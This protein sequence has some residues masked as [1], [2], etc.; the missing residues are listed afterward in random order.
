MSGD[1]P[2][3]SRLKWIRADLAKMPRTRERL[4]FEFLAIAERAVEN[5]A[6]PDNS[7]LLA[8]SMSSSVS[9][10]NVPRYLESI[11][12]IALGC[13]DLM[14]QCPDCRFH[15][16]VL[17]ALLSIRQ[18]EPEGFR[19]VIDSLLQICEASETEPRRRLLLIAK[20]SDSNTRRQVR[21]LI[22]EAHSQNVGSGRFGKS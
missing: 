21:R 6:T 8:T 17:G 22:Q 4:V 11:E 20:S 19:R 15:L 16:P 10:E 7:V 18:M 14:S 5:R 1:L 13:F 3:G 2:A 12:R 9:P